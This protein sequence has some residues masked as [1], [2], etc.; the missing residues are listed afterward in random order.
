MISL[1]DKIIN[2]VS[3]M[4]SSELNKDSII[5]MIK[6]TEEN[7]CFEEAAR[8]L[9]KQLNKPDYNPH[10][11]AHVDNISAKLFSGEKCTS[12]IFDYLQD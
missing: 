1:V 11:V 4:H 12:K 7:A 10:M 5:K 8:V 9:I 2:R 6:D 3:E